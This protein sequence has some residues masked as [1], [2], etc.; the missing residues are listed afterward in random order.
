MFSKVLFKN[1]THQN[2]LY[3][4]VLLYFRNS[5]IHESLYITLYITY[6]LYTPDM[7]NKW[8]KGES[9]VTNNN[10]VNRAFVMSIIKY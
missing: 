8:W 4:L 10:N 6:I 9:I 5:F 7:I 1:A 3:K 2:I